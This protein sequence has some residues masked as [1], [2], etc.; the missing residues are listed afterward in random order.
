M[1]TTQNVFDS[2]LSAWKQLSLWLYKNLMACSNGPGT[3]FAHKS[4][5]VHGHKP[6]QSPQSSC[7]LHGQTPMTP[8]RVKSWSTVLQL[9]Q[10]QSR[11]GRRRVLVLGTSELCHCSLQMMWFW[12]L[13]Q[14]RSL[15]CKAEL[16]FVGMS[17]NVIVMNQNSSAGYDDL[18]H[19]PSP[20]TV[21]LT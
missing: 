4:S 8:P 6:S 11:V 14:T 3:P 19:T 2:V 10:V 9:G 13:Y 20:Q 1:E 5:I 12:W 7:R 16:W 18:F 17:K 15:I 21:W